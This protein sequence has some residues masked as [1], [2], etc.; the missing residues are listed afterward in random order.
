VDFETEGPGVW[1][2][3]YNSG[4]I[5]ST[6]NTWLDLEAGINRVAV[7][8]TRV[9]GAITVRVKGEGLKSASVTIPSALV[10][11]ENGFTIALPQMPDGAAK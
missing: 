8:A 5:K 10:K 11:V 6:N 4:K 3:G 1:R 7:R 9:A 2:G